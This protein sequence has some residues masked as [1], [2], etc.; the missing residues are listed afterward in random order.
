LEEKQDDV[1]DVFKIIRNSTFTSLKTLHLQ[2]ESSD[3]HEI[4]A[5]NVDQSLTVDQWGHQYP[6]LESV[7]IVVTAWAMQNTDMPGAVMASRF[8]RCCMESHNLT[9]DMYTSS[10][11]EY[12]PGDR[13]YLS[14]TGHD[15]VK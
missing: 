11:A 9:M 3:G 4:C 1:W 15:F 10:S 7:H 13:P 14:W 12:N 5:K 2:I 6:A 8:L